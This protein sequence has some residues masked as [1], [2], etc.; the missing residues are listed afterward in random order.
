MIGA[1]YQEA[2]QGVRHGQVI[3]WTLV[4][5]VVLLFSTEMLIITHVPQ[6]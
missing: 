2:H 3:V 6:A 1:D 4:W 5:L